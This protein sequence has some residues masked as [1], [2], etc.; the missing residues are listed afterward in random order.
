[1]AL[2]ELLAF[3]DVGSVTC[4]TLQPKVIE[5]IL[6]H[7][8]EVMKDEQF[9]KQIACQSASALAHLLSHLSSPKNFLRGP[10]FQKRRKIDANLKQSL[11]RSENLPTPAWSA[12]VVNEL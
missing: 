5:S 7:R 3:S 12:A 11:W 8:N 1:M 9:L 6:T 4:P 2:A 10:P